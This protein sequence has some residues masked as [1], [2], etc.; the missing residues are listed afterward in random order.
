MAG[1]KKEHVDKVRTSKFN[2]QRAD[3]LTLAEHEKVLVAVEILRSARLRG[4]GCR[5][6]AHSGGVAGP[7][8]GRIHAGTKAVTNRAAKAQLFCEHGFLLLSSVTTVSFCQGFG[9]LQMF[10]EVRKHFARKR[11]QISILT[12]IRF[13]FEQRDGLFVC[14]HL[15]I[16][17][18]PVK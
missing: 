15:I 10:L 8:G 13:F 12:F 2:R 11:F 1:G 17:V 14:H 4:P 9:M 18:G 7:S 3:T 6:Q 5:N 16:G